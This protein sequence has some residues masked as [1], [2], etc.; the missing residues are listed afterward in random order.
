MKALENAHK[1]EIR[2]LIN[3]WNNII[4]PNF[5]NEISLLEIEMKKKHQNE[6]E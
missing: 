4:I 2:E 1:A 6:L 3:K 5:E